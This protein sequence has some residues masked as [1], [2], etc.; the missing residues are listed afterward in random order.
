M[1]GHEKD[2]DPVTNGSNQILEAARDV[3]LL[4]GAVVGS[5]PRSFAVL[6]IDRIV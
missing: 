2:L 5:K 3:A 4:L 6:A 1:F